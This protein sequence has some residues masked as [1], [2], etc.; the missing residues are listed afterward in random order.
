M[1]K[2][3]LIIT[4][5][6]LMY[7]TNTVAQITVGSFDKPES[8]SVLQLEGTG[9]LRLPQLQNSDKPNL[10]T[11]GS[12]AQGL[13]IYNKTNQRLEYWDGTQW[14]PLFQIDV[15]N[16][17]TQNKTGKITLGGT[18]LYNTSIN[19]GTYRLNLISGNNSSIFSVNTDVLVATKQ[20]LSFNP[21]VFTVN[22]NDFV[23]NA[24]GIKIK[25]LTATSPLNDKLEVNNS[26]VKYTGKLSYID[27]RQN[28]DKVL[29]AKDDNG[30]AH[31]ADLRPKSRVKASTIKTT[32]TAIT[33]TNTVISDGDLEL[34]KGEWMILA[35][36]GAKTTTSTSRYL[37][38][39]LWDS[40]DNTNPVTAIGENFDSNRYA[41]VQLVFLVNVT[42]EKAWYNIKAKTAAANAG[43]LYT[44]SDLENYG[45]PYF[46][47][48]LVDE[49]TD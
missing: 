15:L 22:T 48:I 24:S 27:G 18:L 9:G 7:T 41:L 16:G 33:A 45:T 35:G 42:T 30:L 26:S 37:W 14:V 43:L 25:A 46:Y 49:P 38:L 39:S 20:E 44:G 1:N 4:S 29:T 3:I 47:A 6:L 36:V 21:T 31:W 28:V 5:I 23:A 34:T 12:A 19:T 10:G 11:L 13:T 40:A 17:L 32:N 8:F 2:Y